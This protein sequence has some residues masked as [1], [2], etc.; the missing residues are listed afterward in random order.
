[1]FGDEHLIVHRL[2]S[3]R[4]GWLCWFIL[5]LGQETERKCSMVGRV[6]CTNMVANIF[7]LG[8]LHTE[9][10]CAKDQ[11]IPVGVALTV[12]SVLDSVSNLLVYPAPHAAHDVVDDTGALEATRPGTAACHCTCCC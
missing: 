7:H 4:S 8:V 11:V 10:L 12:H 1:V 3:S 6:D 2:H 5:K 9:R